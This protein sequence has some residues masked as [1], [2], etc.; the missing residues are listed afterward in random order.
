MQW[1]ARGLCAEPRHTNENLPCP[2][3]TI[4]AGLPFARRWLTPAPSR[5]LISRSLI[6]D[7]DTGRRSIGLA[8]DGAARNGLDRSGG[9]A[10]WS[11]G[12]QSRPLAGL[13]Q[14]TG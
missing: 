13:R 9:N 2:S 6:R 1:S 11:H 7:S 3:D 14:W 8:R 12:V 4:G 5:T 10:V